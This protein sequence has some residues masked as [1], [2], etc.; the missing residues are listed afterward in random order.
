MPDSVL[1]ES[2]EGIAKAIEI[3]KNDL[4]KLRT[5]RASLA[6]LDSIKVDYYGNKTD[7]KSVANLSIPDARTI[8]IQPWEPKMIGVIEKEIHAASLGVNPTNNGK[9]IRLVM[10]EITEERR[11]DVVKLAKKIGEDARIAIRQVR[12]DANDSLKELEKKKEISEDDLKLFL[13]KVQKEVDSG[14]KEVEE[15]VKTK[16][17]EIMKI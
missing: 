4:L 2:K 14:N 5:G 3:L 7:L 12:K 13:D 10:P 15:I 8:A 9:V 1:K 11:K 17:Q 16:E 6:I